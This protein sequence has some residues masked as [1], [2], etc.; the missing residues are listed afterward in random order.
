MFIVWGS[1]TFKQLFEWLEHS[2]LF[3]V[4]EPW[5]EGFKP[6]VQD[7]L[8][9]VYSHLKMAC[10]TE[11]MGLDSLPGHSP[12]GSHGGRTEACNTSHRAPRPAAW[13][14]WHSSQPLIL[15]PPPT[16]TDT[17]RHTKTHIHILATVEI[18]VF[19]DL[20]PSDLSAS[21]RLFGGRSEIQLCH[22][23]LFYS[24]CLWAVRKSQWDSGCP[25][26]LSSGPFK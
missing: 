13:H 15:E 21:S 18:V 14:G 1:K 2:T 16:H 5:K 20:I 25:L 22:S 11:E 19:F 17:H 6:K 26:V 10:R 4:H 9:W 8:K 23:E 24:L 3:I 12:S 7:D